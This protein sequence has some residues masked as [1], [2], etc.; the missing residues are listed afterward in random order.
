[1]TA[2]PGPWRNERTPYLVGIMDA[3]TEPGVEQVVFLKSAQVGFSESLRNLIGYWIDHD[4]GPALLVMPNQQSAEE[5]VEERIRPLLEETPKLKPHVGTAR[6][7]NKLSAIKCDTMTMYTAWAGSPQA[8][9]S[10]PIR[11]IVFDE[12]DKYPP[13]AGKEADPISLGLKRLTTYGK[14][15]LAVIGSTPTTRHG[16]IYRHWES[17]TDRRRYYVPCPYCREYQELVWPQVKYPSG[18]DDESRDEHAERVE[19]DRLARYECIRCEKHWTDAEKNNAIRQG[20]WRSEKPGAPNRRIGFHISSIYS[21][22]LSM[23]KLAGEWLRSQ[24]DAALL[25]DFRNSRLAE[26]FEERASHTKADTIEAKKTQS[27]APMVVPAWADILIATADVQKDHL[28]WVIR[29]WGHAYRSALIAYGMA[30]DLD[31]LGSLTLGRMFPKE[32]TG[33]AVGA[34]VLGVDAQYRTD[35]VHQFAQRDPGRIWPMAGSASLKAPPIA[36]RWVKGYPGVI[37]RDTNPNY[38]KDILHARVHDDDQTLWL[39]HNQVGEDYQRQMASEH[40]VLDPKNRAWVWVK[41]S[42]GAANHYWD[43]E[44]MQCVLAQLVGVAVLPTPQ[45]RQ[46][47]RTD[48]QQVQRQ[49]GGSWVTGHRGRW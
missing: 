35:E 16:S 33:E 7:D 9:A 21:P 4:P 2:E 31:E 10:R 44:Y 45:Q 37:R 41:V 27:P 17:C 3:T 6:G 28:Y 20:V 47:Q 38:W 14:R 29:G 49:S 13:F 34:V 15:A 26:P 36:E 19:A 24:D 30:T 40:K 43:C 25:M 22:W 42:S 18:R 5:T 11:Y 39:P 23:S 1:M 8:L 12:V 48:H 46:A 32:G